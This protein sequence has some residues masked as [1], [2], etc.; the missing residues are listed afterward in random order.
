MG[1]QRTGERER[2]SGEGAVPAAARQPQ[3][4][5]HVSSCCSAVFAAATDVSSRDGGGGA[6]TVAV[7]V[8]VAVTVAVAAGHRY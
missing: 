4:R 8:A 7:A 1:G 6:E 2:E 3:G 5:W